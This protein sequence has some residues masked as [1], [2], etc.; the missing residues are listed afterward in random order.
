MTFDSTE[1]RGELL[2]VVEQIYAA[3]AGEIRLEEAFE[4]FAALMGDY[5]TA[6]LSHDPVV[7]RSTMEAAVGIERGW[8]EEYNRRWGDANPLMM[9]GI[10]DLMAGR[11]V[12]S[13]GLMPWED[14]RRT[15]FYRE[16]LGPLRCRHSLA[17]MVTGKAQRHATLVTARREEDGPHDGRDFARVEAIRRHLARALHILEFFEG[18]CL[19]LDTYRATIDRLPFSVLL[20]D[21]GAH[22]VHANDI[23]RRRLAEGETLQDRGGVLVS[24][25]GGRSPLLPQWRALMADPLLAE[26]QIGVRGGR[27]QGTPGAEL[28]RLDVRGTGHAGRIWMLRVQDERIDPDALA[29]RWRCMLGLTDAECRT[30]RALLRYGSTRAAAAQLGRSENTVREHLKHM[31]VKTG[32]SNQAALTVKLLSVA[33]PR[34]G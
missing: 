5:A 3:A 30:A 16:F 12:T 34:L 14:L 17:A 20:L 8:L 29:A 27:G 10:G 1:D 18:Q 23:A 6:M 7:G 33:A 31:F 32:T 24:L 9:R 11:I 4:S 22:I 2:G 26:A 13:D 15:D 28:S 21:D 19:W 25:D